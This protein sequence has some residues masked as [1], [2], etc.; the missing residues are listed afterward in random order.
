MNNPDVDLSQAEVERISNS[1]MHVML[2]QS[3]SF[4]RLET[5]PYGLNL[6]VG[7]TP[8]GLAMKRGE[9]AVLGRELLRFAVKGSLEEQV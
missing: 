7:G 4:W 3:G 8:E 6:Y 9:A 5:S 1:E 2:R